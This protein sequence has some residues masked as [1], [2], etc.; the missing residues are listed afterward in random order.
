MLRL[1][2]LFG[3]AVWAAPHRALA[4]GGAPDAGVPARVQA[5]VGSELA[6]EAAR[7]AATLLDIRTRLAPDEQVLEIATLAGPTRERLEG[8]LA[9][10]QPDDLGARDL[11]EQRQAWSRAA[12]NIETQQSTLSARAAA[13]ETEV[14]IVDELRAR[15]ETTRIAEAALPSGAR[16]QI[17]RVLEDIRSVRLAIQERQDDVHEVQRAVSESQLLITEV[18]SQLDR[19]EAQ[20]RD[21]LDEQ[22]RPALWASSDDAD[23]AGRGYREQ[24]AAFSHADSLGHAVRI[25]FA[26]QLAPLAW[27]LVL[28]LLGWTL[29]RYIARHRPEE[30]AVLPP[31]SAAVFAALIVTPAL[32]PH[33]P[34][35]V[36]DAV[37]LFT[38]PVLIRLAAPGPRRNLLYLTLPSVIADSV[39]RVVHEDSGAHRALLLIA[40][41]LCVVPAA[42]LLWQCRRDPRADPLFNGR[43]MIVAE[44]TLVGLFVSVV[45]NVLGFMPLAQLTTEASLGAFYLAGLLTM[46]VSLVNDLLVDFVATPLARRS[47]SIAN[48]PDVVV[49]RTRSL[50]YIGAV[51]IWSYV[52]LESL[53]VATPL[54]EWVKR[55]ASHAYALGEISLSLVDVLAFALALY[56]SYWLSRLI[57]FLLDEDV[58]PRFNLSRGVPT[59]ISMVTRYLIIGLGFLTAVAAAGVDLS[60]LAFLAGALGVGVGFGLQNVVGNFVSG[61]ILMFE[62]PVKVGDIIE[63]GQLLG[64]VRHIG[65][66]ASTV[67]T[68]SGAEVIVPNQNLIANEVVNWTLS[69]RK[70]RVEIPVGVAYGTDIPSVVALLE[71][72]VKDA[73][74]VLQVP[75]P[76]VIFSAFGE[77]SL[78]FNVLVWVGEHDDWFG[79]QTRLAGRIADVLERE[80]IEIPFPQRVLHRA[81]ASQDSKEPQ[82]PQEPEPKD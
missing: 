19:V 42:R 56:A 27:Q 64:E 15:W 67:R 11:R 31:F 44:F 23:D 35:L 29:V 80:N 55:K 51:L 25:F 72:A 6:S 50:M 13:L 57:G 5:I 73:E 39:R 65:I 34:A 28:F 41:L 24:T 37:V 48:H 78:D 21:M 52:T 70:K 3:A 68:K 77:S 71:E 60:Q 30:R 63:V 61:L 79:V 12:A 82:K 45:S 22:T 4:Q 40:A 7:T 81:A 53:R 49:E 10:F 36:F 8:A 2:L 76:S 75:P 17:S 14:A 16:Q 32:H 62:R 1:S 74:D 69:D 54:L 43:A 66:R 9:D 58:L 18:M 38:V 47:K 59:A 26:T 46:V 33:A 20:L